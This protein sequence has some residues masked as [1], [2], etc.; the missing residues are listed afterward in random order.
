MKITTVSDNFVKSIEYF[1]C[2]GDVTHYLKPYLDKCNIPTIGL[3]STRYENG[4]KVS[5]T[6]PSITKDRAYSLFRNKIHQFE[7][8]VDTYCPDDINQ[9]QFDACVDFCYNAGSGGFHT[10]TLLKLIQSGERNLE[11]LEPWF[12]AWDKGMVDGKLVELLGLKRR[13][14]YEALLFCTGQIN[15][16]PDFK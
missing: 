11:K 12:I 16:F 7:L 3:G 2:S 10:S 1:E 15:Y 13:R 5:M 6:D 9:S 4:T 14:K 8:D